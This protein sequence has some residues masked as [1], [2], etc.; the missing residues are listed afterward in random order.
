MSNG[1]FNKIVTL[2]SERFGDTKRT[3]DDIS[4]R[5]RKSLRFCILSIYLFIYLFIYCS[6]QSLSVRSSAHCHHHQLQYHENH[7]CH[8]YIIITFLIYYL[9]SYGF[10]YDVISI[11]NHVLQLQYY[12]SKKK[13]SIFKKTKNTN[14]F[15]IKYNNSYIKMF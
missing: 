9:F 1:I 6:Q 11:R 5:Q 3:V 10:W 14:N 8:H 12:F 2:F 7:A 13:C 4:L 15:Y